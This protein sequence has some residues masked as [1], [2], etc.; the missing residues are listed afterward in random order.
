ML[1]QFIRL[2]NIFT[3]EKTE[4]G[5]PDT[6]RVQALFPDSGKTKHRIILLLFGSLTSII[7]G[8]VHY[9]K[10]NDSFPTPIERSLW[11]VSCCIA[12][13]GVLPIVL[14]S[15]T[16]FSRQWLNE[17]K[18]WKSWWKWKR[19]FDGTCKTLRVITAVFFVTAR[20]FLVVEAFVSIRIRTAGA[21]QTVKWMDYFAKTTTIGPQ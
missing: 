2:P 6:V 10:W 5:C 1:N 4:T 21:Y 17:K 11:R 20:I 8:G 13:S 12:T 15:I 7:Y 3:C 14:L 18:V 16:G 9:I 19:W